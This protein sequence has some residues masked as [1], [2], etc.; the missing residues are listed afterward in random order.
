MLAVGLVAGFAGGVAL[1]TQYGGDQDPSVRS[2]D[3]NRV[4]SEPLARRFNRRLLNQLLIDRPT[5]QLPPRQWPPR[6][7]T[8]RGPS[9]RMPLT[10]EPKPLATGQRASVGRA[11]PIPQSTLTGLYVQSSP[12]GADVYLDDKL[13]STTPFQLSDIMPG[14]TPSGS[15]GQGYR[16][17]SAPVNI[18]PGARTNIS[19]VLER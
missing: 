10:P 19:A 8:H 17:W 12:S 15:T 1:V 5:I 14:R 4:D 16:S 7:M 13:V 6:R 2:L 11:E 18:E 3:V 9:K